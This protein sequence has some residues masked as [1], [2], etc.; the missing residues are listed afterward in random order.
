MDTASLDFIRV[1]KTSS[2]LWITPTSRD[3]SE[4]WDIVI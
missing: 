4:K 3:F 1:R 2:Q